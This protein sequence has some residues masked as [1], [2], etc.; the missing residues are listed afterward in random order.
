MNFEKLPFAVIGAGPVGLA[1]L[2]HLVKRGEEAVLFEAAPR[3]AGNIETWAHVRIFSP[4]QYCID[5][6]SREI[7][8][9]SGWAEPDCDHLPTGAELISQYLKPLAESA[10]LNPFI[11]YNSKVTAISRLRTDKMRDA[12]RADQPFMLRIKSP[13]GEITQYAKAVIDASG[14]WGTLAPLG[15]DGLPAMGEI[16]HR[17]KIYYG[18]PDVLRNAR[19]R[20]ENKRVAVVGGGHSAINAILELAELAEES[21]QTEIVWVLRTANVSDSFGGGEDDLLPARGQLG[22]RI[23]KLVDQKRIRVVAPFFVEKI[24]ASE[25]QLCLLGE[26]SDGE[27]GLLVDE[28]IAATGTRPDLSITSELRLSLDPSVESPVALAPLIDPNIHSCGTVPPHGE[29]ELRHPE[30]NF[31]VVGMKSYGRA[32]T[33]LMLTG[34]EQVRSVVAAIAGDHEAARNV[35]LELPATGVCG[36]Q[37]DSKLLQIGQKVKSACC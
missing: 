37:G 14:T 5:S 2:A 4:W 16:E 27:Q 10:Q 35:E 25:N 24:D 6:A 15:A 20:Y 28:I 1:A 7:L 3:V 36:G 33:F 34:Y 30:P 22:Q 26:T 9:R 29:A 19:S 8:E 17:E 23:K 21:E 12:N 13:D 11:H 31:Y 18:I 32:P